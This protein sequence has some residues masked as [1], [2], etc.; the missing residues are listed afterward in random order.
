M[1]SAIKDPWLIFHKLTVAVQELAR[2]HEELIN[3]SGREF[4]GRLDASLSAMAQKIADEMKQAQ[5]SA[6]VRVDHKPFQ[7][8]HQQNLD[9]LN[10]M[11]QG[12]MGESMQNRTKGL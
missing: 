5:F 7:D 12:M 1:G 2:Q 6:E 8:M 10:G 3:R 11:F 4:S 9:A